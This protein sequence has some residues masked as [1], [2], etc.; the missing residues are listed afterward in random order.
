MTSP[1]RQ[2]LLKTIAQLD[3]ALDNHEQWHKNIVRSLI[4]RAAP[5]PADLEP[6]AHRHC[7]LGQWYGSTE[8]QP[9]RKHPAFLALGKAHEQMH[10][11]ATSL[12]LK[13]AAQA[14]IEPDEIDDFSNA[15]DRLKLELQS[16][17][18]ELNEYIQN[19][20]P[21]T[22]AR[23]RVNMLPDLRE[24]HSL[25]QRGVQQ[26]A[27]AILDLDHFKEMNDRYGHLTGDAVLASAVERLEALVRPYDRIYR[28][29][30]EEFL[31]CM[32]NTTVDIAVNLVERLR[33]AL[34]ANEVRTNNLSLRVTASFG[35]A[36]LDGT[37]TV[38]ESIDK[39]DKAM[40]LAKKR[41][42]NRVEA[43]S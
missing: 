9:L 21:L 38:E 40:Y 18:T 36:A 12:L 26:C 23:N 3:Q 27:I 2:Q 17:R 42:R 11:L 33:A 14:V 34:E 32:P 7:R 30:G 39:A 35:V 24:Q 20:D 19:H 29:G 13:S 43:E 10:A 37:R 6:D 25:V 22:G 5:D 1:S 16:L 4:T 31:L 28:Y 41:G 8:T 15:R